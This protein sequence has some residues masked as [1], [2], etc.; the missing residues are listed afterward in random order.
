MCTVS[1]ILFIGAPLKQVFLCCVVVLLVGCASTPSIPPINAN[2]TVTLARGNYKMIKASAKGVSTGFVLLAIPFGVPTY[3]EA[4][5]NLYASLGQNL[6]GRSIALINQTCD[7]GGPWLLVVYFPTITITADV[8][9]FN[10]SNS[11]P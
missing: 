9:E 6:E 7:T 1:K 11:Y 10:S 5:A 3:A 4:K 2:D 8:I